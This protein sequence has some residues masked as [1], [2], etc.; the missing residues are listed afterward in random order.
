MAMESLRTQIK[1]LEA[2]IEV[3]EEKIQ[4]KKTKKATAAAQVQ[5]RI[6]LERIFA[7]YMDGVCQELSVSPEEALRILINDEST[8]GKIAHDNPEAL[9]ELV[10]QPGVKVITAIAVHGGLGNVSEEWIEQKMTLLLEVMRKIRPS[11]A[12]V[13]I[14]TPGGQKW[15]Y[16]SLIG[17]RDTLFGMPQLKI[18]G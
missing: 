12:N 1:E 2:D 13:I 17:L 9:A 6:F 7:P 3:L 15:F 18:E 11:L 16:D 8:L 10:N 4:A 14:T 5:A